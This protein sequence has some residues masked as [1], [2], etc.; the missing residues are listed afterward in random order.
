MTKITHAVYT[1]VKQKGR[2]LLLHNESEI[3][4]NVV[5][6]RNLFLMILKNCWVGLAYY[7]HTNQNFK[8]KLLP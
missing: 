2:P 4:W 3:N 6:Q 8:G 1:F 5:I 7:L